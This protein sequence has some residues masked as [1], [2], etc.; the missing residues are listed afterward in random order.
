[1]NKE[2][3]TTHSLKLPVLNVLGKEVSHVDLDA[4][5]FNVKPHKQSMFDLIIK[6]RADERQGTKKT[7]T[8]TEVRGGGKK[9]W[10]QKHTGNARAGSIRSPIWRG[11]GIVHGP[12]PNTNYTVKLNK[13][14]IKLALKSGWTTKLHDHSI[15]LVDKVNFQTP[16]SKDFKKMLKNIKADERRVLVILS[17]D[18]ENQ[19]DFS[20]HDYNT[21][22]SG[23]NISNVL[24]VNHHNVKLDD[25]L[26]ATKIVT[27]PEILK[28]IEGGLK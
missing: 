4:S 26:K 24:V 21:Y 5:V 22:L 20:A 18:T 27:T 11:G 9:P 3:T 10:A 8:R 23:R 19:K 14:V 28:H 2:I 6:E 25:M 13:K 15:V 17:A 16:S 7:K 12:N 1:M